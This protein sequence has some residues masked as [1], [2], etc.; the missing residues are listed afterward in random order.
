MTQPSLHTTFD[1]SLI[2]LAAPASFSTTESW[3]SEGGT[4]TESI[5]EPNASTQTAEP[6]RG[7]QLIAQSIIIASSQNDAEAIGQFTSLLRS[8]TPEA[9][10]HIGILGQCI[11][12][13][14]YTSMQPILPH[15]TISEHQ[16]IT[17][18]MHN[19][20][21]ERT[22]LSL[23]FDGLVSSIEAGPIAINTQLIRLNG[24][25]QPHGCLL[26][27]LDGET[28]GIH[29]KD[30]D[31]AALRTQFRVVEAEIDTNEP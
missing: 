15:S 6:A 19:N 22:P 23:K 14:M 24:L 7:A 13:E 2:D 4:K 11:D 10:L 26:I 12:F 30:L 16:S 18:I 8:A 28:Q 21:Q 20:L 29:R 25:L 27:I 5:S 1:T 17:W 3:P 9:S 31:D